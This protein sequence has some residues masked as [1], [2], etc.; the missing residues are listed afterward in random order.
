[1]KARITSVFSLAGVLVAGSAAALVN[2][3]VL[4]N[5][6]VNAFSATDISV[7]SPAEALAAVPQT[8]TTETVPV[9]VTAA[10]VQEAT[11]TQA[12][13]Q[14]GLAGS[15]TLDT[16]GD[17]LSVV[18]ATPADGWQVTKAEAEDDFSAEAVFQSNT[19]RVEFKAV[20]LYGV[21]GVSVEAH[22][23][24]QNSTA[25]STSKTTATS[26]HGDDG[27]GHESDHEDEHEDEHHEDGHHGGSDHPED[28]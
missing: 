26:H 25:P 19:T 23:L 13:Y 1:M 11:T 6:S 4:Q 8:H 27:S 20:L 10:A 9:V 2:T 5:S 22:D 14:V 21:V 24:T 18:I 7:S 16:A 15:I 12:T 3:Q 17:H 28:D